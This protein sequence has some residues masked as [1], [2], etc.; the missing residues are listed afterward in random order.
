M[1]VT[2]GNDLVTIQHAQSIRH[3]VFTLEQ[4]IPRKLDLDGLDLHSFHALATDHS[5]P[6]GTARLTLATDGSAV[7]ARV[8]VLSAYRG[9]GIAAK[10]VQTLID[11]AASIGVKTIEIHAHEYLKCYYEKFGFRCIKEVEVVSGHQLI[12][13]QLELSHSEQGTLG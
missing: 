10:V 2:I 5:N 1:E 6:I 13:M 12:Q 11:H 4:N 9:S 7:M 8:A 3:Q